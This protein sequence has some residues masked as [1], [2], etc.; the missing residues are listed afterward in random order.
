MKG[1]G[2]VQLNN[3]KRE[4]LND[5]NKR[6][7]EEMLTYIRL[8]LNRSEQQT[9]E[10][11]M[12]LLDHLLEGQKQGKSAQDIFG[13]DLKAYCDELIAEIPKERASVN[14]L[15][16][17]YLGL[18]LAGTVGMTLGILSYGLYHLFDLGTPDF[19]FSL[20]S[21][22]VIAL[23]NLVLIALFVYLIFAF[24][25]G[26]LFKTKKTRKWMEF[27]QLWLISSLFIGISIAI[28]L[29]MPSFGQPLSIPYLVIVAIAGL[30]YLV[31][32]FINKKF[33]TVK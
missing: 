17:I 3:E 4:Q 32:V 13:E 12:E 23:V 31:S 7:Y 9:E 21:G 26:S 28:G 30:L 18:N 15:F 6:D 19:T 8:N 27:L 11:L 20:G 1:K 29:W 33:L 10:V 16:I 5:S 24:I 22:L 14:I 25:N 2:L